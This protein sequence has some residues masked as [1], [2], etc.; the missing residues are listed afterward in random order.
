MADPTAEEL[1]QLIA[2]KEKEPEGVELKTE[3]GAVFKGKDW[4]DIAQQMK[5][6]VESGTRTIKQQKDHEVQLRQQLQQP[7]ENIKES[8]TTDKYHERWITDPAGAQNALLAEQL[9]IPENQLIPTLRQTFRDTQA[10]NGAFQVSQF[11]SMVP[12]YTG[13]PEMKSALE[14]RMNQEGLPYTARN[15]RHTFR[16]LV[17]EKV[18]KTKEV[19]PE[20]VE[21]EHKVDAPPN[22]EGSG[23][24][25]Q[26]DII[27]KAETMDI[28][29]LEAVLRSAKPSA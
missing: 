23:A 9:G 6:S 28:N 2:A 5:V 21:P 11:R 20:T 24:N 26:E 13:D 8:T 18:I 1:K 10:M 17:E 14:Q 16:D 7:P 19:K 29:E 3:T 27:Q 4:H 25:P 12:E 15:L 22:L